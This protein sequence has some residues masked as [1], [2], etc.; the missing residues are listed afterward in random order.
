VPDR[1]AITPESIAIAT[2]VTS[3]KRVNI[4]RSAQH[5]PAHDKDEARSQD[6]A[7]TALQARARERRDRQAGHGQRQARLRDLFANEPYGEGLAK[8]FS[9]AWKQGRQVQGQTDHPAQGP[10]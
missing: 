8:D 6:A 5:A 7:P 10:V 1:A 2:G 3:Q 9:A 4:W